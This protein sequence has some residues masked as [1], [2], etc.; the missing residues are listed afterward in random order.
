MVETAGGGLS[1][2]G[3]YTP[4]FYAAQASGA[5]ASAEAVVPIACELVQPASVVDVGCG[6]GVWLSVFAEHGILD[7]QGYDGE[8]VKPEDLAIPRS[9]FAAANLTEPLPTTRRFD[10]AVSLEVA[11]HL[12]PAHASHFVSALT[13]LS[14]VVLFSAA[15]PGQGGTSH[16][17]EQWPDYWAGEFR[18]RGYEAVDVIR[19]RIWNDE[20]VKWW[21]R[22]NTLLYVAT[23]P[24]DP[25][26]QIQELRARA[27]GI[28]L[29]LVHPALYDQTRNAEP[30]G[31]SLG[32]VIR[33]LPRLIARAITQRARGRVRG[34][35]E[36]QG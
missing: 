20:R 7:I 28:P 13:Q 36:G 27:D 18:A 29:R 16:L 1:V 12:P 35:E 22:Q 33:A 34:D 14:D 26:P 24:L 32:T 11:E 25:R 2:E 21:Y 17:N 19:K 5:R 10:L 9:A 6:T 8:W 15:I 23:N 31:M 3:A 30:A 4:D